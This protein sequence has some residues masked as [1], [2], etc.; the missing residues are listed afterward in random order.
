[1]LL[2]AEVT[3]VNL[4]NQSVMTK[5]FRHLE[6]SK[7]LIATGASPRVIPI[8]GGEKAKNIRYLRTPD[9]ANAIYNEA[10]GQDIVIVGSGFI[11]QSVQKVPL[12][13]L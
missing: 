4:V 13:S 5:R 9:D 3:K 11:G 1:M 6:Y 7:L 8:R 10:K 12:F 2:D